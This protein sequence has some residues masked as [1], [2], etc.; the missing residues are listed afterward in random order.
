MEKLVSVTPEVAAGINRLVD[1][2]ETAVQNV[3]LANDYHK[4]RKAVTEHR[5]AR[6]V[7]VNCIRSL[8]NI[9][10]GE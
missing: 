6:R 1:D 9:A 4:R 5:R 7:L 8:N 2:F 10:A 3:T